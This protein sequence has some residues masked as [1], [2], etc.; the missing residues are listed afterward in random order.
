MSAYILNEELEPVKHGETGELC[1]AGSA[2]ALGYWNA[3]ELTARAFVQRGYERIYRTGDLCHMSE[4]GELI[5]EGRMDGQVKVKG[6]RIELGEVEN[7]AHC[8]EG[9]ENCCALFDGENKEIVLFVESSGTLPYNR[10]NRALRRYIPAY[11]LPSRIEVYEKLPLTPNG[12]IDRVKLRGT[13]GG[14]K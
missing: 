7:A 4:D 11:M 1:I 10:F 12:K 5:Y 13:F 8:I 6:N 3:P 14:T 9:V 2:L